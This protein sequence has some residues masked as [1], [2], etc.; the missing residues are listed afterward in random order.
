MEEQFV[1]IPPLQFILEMA[2]NHLQAIGIVLQLFAGIILALPFIFGR[3][4]FN[5]LDRKLRSIFSWPSSH[6]RWLIVVGFIIAIVIPILVIIVS[7]IS[8][9][10]QPIIWYNLV[11]YTLFK[12]GLAGLLYMIL[13]SSFLKILTKWK[14]IYERTAHTYWLFFIVNIIT[15]VILSLLFYSSLIGLQAF[16]PISVSDLNNP[17]TRFLIILLL[18]LL[19]SFTLAWIS[20]FCF[21]VLT[22]S[23]KIVSSIAS[24]IRRPLWVVVLTIYVLGGICLLLN[25]YV[26][27]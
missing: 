13:V 16:Y 27:T 7:I 24:P 21:V 11:L 2:R 17:S 1:N 10:E 4:P 6:S 22:G 18:D 26:P 25:V 12:G 20:S 8:Q 5:S 15:L 14:R 19:Q 9:A 3:R 23:L